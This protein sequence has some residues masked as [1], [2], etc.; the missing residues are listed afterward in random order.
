VK[1]FVRL[2]KGFALESHEIAFGNFDGHCSTQFREERLSLPLFF[3]HSLTMQQLTSWCSILVQP[4]YQK[5]H[6]GSIMAK[7]ASSKPRS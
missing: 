7:Q 4:G 6:L 5:P 3:S 1:F 2:D